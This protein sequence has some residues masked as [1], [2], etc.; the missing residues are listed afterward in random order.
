LCKQH[1]HG[2]GSLRKAVLETDGQLVEYPR[3]VGDGLGPFPEDVDIGQLKQLAYCL[4]T[5][6]DA[7]ILVTLRSWR[8]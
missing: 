2:G 1:L 8:L 6:K 3:P 4:L 5:G 7:L